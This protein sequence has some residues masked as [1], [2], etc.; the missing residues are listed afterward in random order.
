MP[1]DVGGEIIIEDAVLAGGFV[2]VPSAV[3]FDPDLSPGAKV[4][5][6]A[7]LWYA[8]RNGRF[9]GQKAMA[10]ELGGGESTIRR[11]LAELEKAGYIEARVLGLGRPNQYV[12][13]SLG[14]VP[15]PDRSKMSGLAA[16]KRAVKPPK[17]ERSSDVVLDVRTDDTPKR[18]RISGGPRGAG[19]GGAPSPVPSLS[20]S[21]LS[22]RI[23]EALQVPEQA[24]SIRGFLR[25]K[26]NGQAI[27]SEVA[28]EALRQ[29]QERLADGDGDPVRNPA[30]YWTRKCEVLRDVAAL[31]A[32]ADADRREGRLRIAVSVARAGL[33]RGWPVDM[34]L[35][36]VRA[37]FPELVADVQA[38]LQGGGA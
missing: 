10:R 20:L 16:Q 36:E 14:K 9:P 21:A 15:V 28:L 22:S 35:S 32:R 37:D 23:A 3:V 1:E 25:G 24:K 34:A 2:Q 13:R 6:G 19:D 8:W 4:S 38:A 11:H 31:E 18:E 12:V 5:Y 29:T 30:A 7:L 17:N 27:P 26:G 33:D